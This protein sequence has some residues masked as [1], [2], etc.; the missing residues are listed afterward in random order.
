MARTKAGSLPSYQLH[1]ASGKAV[2]RIAGRDIY[3]GEHG[4]RES[5]AEY[6]KVIA[7]YLSC[8]HVRASGDSDSQLTIAELLVA[9]WEHAQAYYVKNGT[10]TDEQ[11]AIRK[12]IKDFGALFGDL[13]AS[14]VGPKVLKAIR[15]LWIERGL[16]RSYI[17]QNVGRIVRGFKWA[18]S[19][20]L[21]SPVIMEG[22]RAVSGLR[23]GR[24]L[25]REGKRVPPVALDVL[26]RTIPHL[27]KVVADMIRF[28]LFTGA[29]PG[30]VCKIRPCDIDRSND[31]WEYHVEGHKMEH[32]ERPRIV[33]IGPEAQA[34]LAPYLLRPA[35]QPCFSPSESIADLRARRHEARKTKASYG[36][37]PGRKRDAGG[38]KGEN[39]LW[40]PRQA[41]TTGSYGQAIKR[42]CDLA[43]PA[44]EPLCKLAGETN[45]QHAERLTKKQHAELEEWRRAQRWAPNQ[46]RHTRGTEVR[47]KHGLEAAQVILGHAA[48]DVTQIYAER[49]AEK[50]REVARL[51]G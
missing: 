48:A 41:F 2:V 24:S 19:E 31:V 10:P 38:L 18:V 17:N 45:A 26:Y 29:R 33:F 25:A 22:L 37:A 51:S 13:P 5:K 30:E 43:F 20:E 6:C 49:D 14:E 32:H 4:T 35:D 1:S 21:V 15:T 7:E 12:V 27:S 50:A 44:P 42:G 9:Y 8:G 16:S 34:I 47:K 40:K 39:A 46:I 3:L 23:K 11:N 36:N 28:Q